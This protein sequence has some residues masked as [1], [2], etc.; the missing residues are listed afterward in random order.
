MPKLLQIN[1]TLNLGSTGKIAEQIGKLVLDDGWESFIAWGRK[2]N[3]S[4]SNSIHIGN[5]LVSLFHVFLKHLFDSDGL[6]SIIATKHLIKKIN[7]IS[8][9][10]IH[11]HVLHQGFINYPLLFE[12]LKTLSTPVVWTLHDCWAFT[13]HCYHFDS[14][15]C[16]KWKTQCE[17]CPIN[18]DLSKLELFINSSRNFASK[19][20]SFLSVP[21]M[22]IVPVSFWL[23]KQVRQSFL[24]NYN[25]RVIHNG[26]DLDIFKPLPYDRMNVKREFGSCV[27]LGVSNVWNAQKGYSDILELARR[28]PEWF[29][30]I[31]G[32]TKVQ[33][34]GL[35]QNVNG[36]LFTKNQNE[37]AE[38]YNL[39]DV[40]VNPTY[41][42]TY[43]TVN[44]ESIACGTPVVTY[45]TG[46]S[47]ESITEETGLVAE[48]GNI[49]DLEIKIKMLLNKGKAYFS[50]RCRKY[51]VGHFDMHDCFKAYL[52]LYN[53][54]LS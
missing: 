35:P 41:E 11:L 15:G 38:Y 3:D 33:L 21:R 46:G 54:L 29:F 16:S 14:I 45:N 31:I 37:L 19:K 22:T 44:L 17:K 10:I 6:G 28:N 48:K 43:P 8:P 1:V 7:R 42:D 49:K 26:V 20:A 53:E 36:I 23:D 34:K 40:F 2:R 52:D 5:K 18:K 27:V 51:A 13:G 12:Y 50:P 24:M 9:D 39:A 4:A 30:I 47:P 32:L 25:R